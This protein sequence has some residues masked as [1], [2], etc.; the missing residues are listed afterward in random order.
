MANHFSALKRMRQ[1]RK[2]AELN[3][4]RRSHLRHAVRE[5]RRAI[6]AGDAGKAR[7][8]LS[9]TISVIDRSLKKGI[10]KENT[11][12]RFKSRLMAHLAALG[13]SPAAA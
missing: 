4:A 8:L 1:S 3:R 12:S 2:R 5:L 13:K 7:E 6:L 9:Q 11:A 10:I